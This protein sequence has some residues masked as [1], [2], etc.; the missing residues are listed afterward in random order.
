MLSSSSYLSIGG[1]EI[2]VAFTFR[3]ECSGFDI[4]VVSVER[5]PNDFESVRV[6]SQELWFEAGVKTEHIL[7]DQDLSAHMWTG[8]NTDSWNLEKVRYCSRT[9]RRHTLEHDREAS[10]IF[11]LARLGGQNFQSRIRAGLHFHS[12]QP[13]N[14]LRC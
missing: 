1:F 4:I 6:H 14:R 7:V 12:S 11:Q 2:S 13:V 10:G 9:L 3:W 5:R 8:P